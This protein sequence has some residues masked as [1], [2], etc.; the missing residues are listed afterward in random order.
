MSSIVHAGAVQAHILLGSI[1]LVLYWVALLAVKGS[2]PHKA[3]GRPFFLVLVVVALSVAPLLLLRAGP[4]D[5]GYVV[6]FIYLAVALVTV[7]TIG[8]TA[9]RWKSLPE[10]FRGPHFK[11]LGPVL[12][13]LGLVVLAAGLSRRDP[14]AAVLSWVG[15]AYGAAMVRFAWLRAPLLPTW[16][17]NWHLNAVCGL[18]TAVHG[19]LLGVLWRW[20]VQPDISREGIALIHVLVLVIAIGLRLED[21]RRRGVPLRSSAARPAAAVPTAAH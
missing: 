8:W 14:V 5:P 17:L 9:I 13:V 7:S 15:L 19:T 2:A 3:A 4:F 16:W 18:F 21:G 12:L 10:R 11:V 6:Q 20:A 1:A